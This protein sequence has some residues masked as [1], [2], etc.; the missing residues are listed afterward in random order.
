MLSHNWGASMDRKTTGGNPLG[1]HHVR[2]TSQSL[3]RSRS[4]T[5]R[6]TVRDDWTGQTRLTSTASGGG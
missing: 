4:A 1:T 2:T 6:V 5:R 3:A